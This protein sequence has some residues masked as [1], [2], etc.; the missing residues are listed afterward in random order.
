[1]RTTLRVVS[2]LFLAA[3]VADVY[4]LTRHNIPLLVAGG[5]LLVAA[6]LWRDAVILPISLLAGALYLVGLLVGHVPYDAGAAFVGVALVG[7]ADVAAWSAATPR[8][9][10]VPAASL[11][12]LVIQQVLVLAAG[13]GMAAV[14]VIGRS[15]ASRASIVPWLAGLALLSV[16]LVIPVLR[17]GSDR[18]PR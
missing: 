1:M 3:V 4:V 12:R 10:A 7:Y 5:A 8:R 17:P 18:D 13:A 11:L 14:V 16:A 15:Q 2:L 6:A 9:A